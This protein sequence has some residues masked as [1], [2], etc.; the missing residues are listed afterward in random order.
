[1]ARGYMPGGGGGSATSDDCTATKAQVLEGY[2]AVTSDSDDEAEEGTMPNRGNQQKATS[3][4][5]GNNN[6]YFRTP[7]G[8]YSA[9]GSEEADKPEVYAPYSDVA[10]KGGV[11]S[12]KLLAGQSALGV[13]GE[14]TNDANAGASDIASGKSGYVKGK[15]VNGSLAVYS[16]GPTKAPA[17]WNDSDKVYFSIRRGIYNTLAPGDPNYAQV[18]RLKSDLGITAGKIAQGQSICGVNGT[19]KGL[20]NAAVG[21]VLKGKKFSTASLSNATGTLEIQSAISF[22][23]AA[24]SQSVIRISWKNP[25]KGPWEGIFV[26]ISTTGF[27]GTSGGTRKYT[28]PGVNGNQAGGDNYVDITGLEPGTK[29]YFTCCSYCDGIGWG[30]NYNVSAKTNNANYTLGQLV[31]NDYFSAGYF[32]L[33]NAYGPDNDDDNNW[34]VIPVDTSNNPNGYGE[35]AIYKNEHSSPTGVAFDYGGGTRISSFRI[36]LFSDTE[37]KAKIV[38]QSISSRYEKVQFEQ[39]SGDNFNT[40]N[41]TS[42]RD[43][44]IHSVTYKGRPSASSYTLPVSASY[45]FPIGTSST[46]G[47]LYMTE[48]ILYSD[49]GS[50]SVIAP[51]LQKGGSSGYYPLLYFHN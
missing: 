33:F 18:Y 50:S 23:A 5:T 32:G 26:Q 49:T 2:K 48:I 15:K 4:T 30:T 29:Y 11:T 14:A 28:G 42:R 1:M 22:S 34:L 21:H 47:N 35:N 3:V 51:S 36:L 46:W 19:Y 27:P 31:N 43:Y 7:A 40:V 10:S 44:Q 37:A 6:M 24:R 9:T 20:G 8:Y 25:S 17:G 39:R 41:G 12:A 16:A 38:Q 13:N 45:N